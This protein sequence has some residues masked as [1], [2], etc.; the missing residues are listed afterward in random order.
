MNSWEHFSEMKKEIDEQIIASLKNGIVIFGCGV[1]GQA[2]FERLKKE[3]HVQCF[4]EI[5]KDYG[6]WAT[7]KETGFLLS[8]LNKL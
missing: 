8:H 2:A 4:C 1:N 7:R 6:G 5:I 3:Y